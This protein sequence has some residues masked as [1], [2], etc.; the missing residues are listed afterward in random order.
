VCAPDGF[1]GKVDIVTRHYGI[2]RTHDLAELAAAVRARLR[3]L[4]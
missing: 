3:S 4:G 1:D 2:H